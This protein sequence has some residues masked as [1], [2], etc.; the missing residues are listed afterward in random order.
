[1]SIKYV[2]C[3]GTGRNGTNYL[4]Q[5]LS[6]TEGCVAEHEP[7]PR[8]NR[9]PMRRFLNDDPGAMKKLMPRKLAQ[10]ATSRAGAKVYVE[11]N[12]AFI[13]GFG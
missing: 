1:M 2:F 10:I 13:K 12:H 9:E 8:C 3:I 5:I 7:A 6:S 4:K 11:T